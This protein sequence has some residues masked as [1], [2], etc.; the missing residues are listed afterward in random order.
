MNS[1]KTVS[2]YQYQPLI[3]AAGNGFRMGMPKLFCQFHNIGFLDLIMNELPDSLM[4][5]VVIIR[6]EYLEKAKKTYP[7]IENWL[8]NSS[9]ERGMISSI[10]IGINNFSAQFYI[11]IPID[12]PFVKKETYLSLIHKSTLNKDCII[13]PRYYGLS[14]H[15]IIIPE[16]LKGCFNGNME[17][18]RSV[19]SL[20]KK[21]VLSF[22]FDDIG[23]VK[24]I[25]Y[26]DDLER[27]E[28]ESFGL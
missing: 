5:P 25:N 3:L 14:G 18:L 4:D 22:D 15:P 11:I 26:K 27:L 10:E 13:K 12:F 8:I 21:N 7:S 6:N 23:L 16:S 17:S 19:I 9:P 1:L 20:S 24:N 28:H 2:E